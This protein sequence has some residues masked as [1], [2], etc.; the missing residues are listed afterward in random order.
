MAT[1]RRIEVLRAIVSDFV[2]EGEPV[3]SKTL[4]ERHNLDVSPATIRNDMAQLEEEGYLYQP[5]T[6]AGRIPTPKGYREFVDHIAMLKPVSDPERHAIE[7]FLEGAVDIDD[8]AQRTVRLLA[9]LTH[10]LA[11]VQYPSRKRSGLRH[12]ELVQ[13]SQHQLL[14]VVI[15][16]SGNVTQ[17]VVECDEDLDNVDI[18]GLRIILNTPGADVD[19]M[20]KQLG[21]NVTPAQQHLASRIVDLVNSSL[22]KTAKEKVVVAGAANLVRSTPDFTGSIVPVL[23]ALEEHMTLL[24]LFSQQDDEN[25]QVNVSI[26][27]ENDHNALTE[28]AVVSDT[29]SAEDDATAHL[30][31]I[32]PIRMDYPAT[33]SSVRAVARYLTRYLAR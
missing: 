28:T 3:G 11:V 32:G 4:V 10:Q 13:V 23:D 14:V 16:D 8:I 18:M 30:G 20:L 15:T 31:V 9:Q 24:R 2:R 29:Y 12:L 7:R 6:S 33:M 19:Q 27:E 25:D 5:H 17:H 26:G 21:R 22:D 1:E